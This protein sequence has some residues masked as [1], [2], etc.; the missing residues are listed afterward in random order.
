M[1][2]TPSL[3]T[4]MT[5]TLAGGG[6]PNQDHVV[7]TPHAVAVLDGATAERSSPSGRDGG[8]YAR[9]LGAALVVGLEDAWHALPE[10]VSGAVAGLRERHHLV[11]QECPTSTVA[12]ACWGSGVL[13]VYVLGD[14]P[15]VVYP[16]D[17][18]PVLVQDDRLALVGGAERARYQRHLAQGHG[19]D[20]AFAA[21]LAE[22]RAVQRGRRNRP[23]GYW[24][25][26][27]DPDAAAQGVTARFPLAGTAGVLLVTDGVADDVTQHGR[28]TWREV[29]ALVTS[30]DAG[31]YLRALHEVE[32]SD[33]DGRRW[34][35]AKPHD[36]KTIAYV[37][38]AG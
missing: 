13:D 11:P 27:S 15:A 3:I 9:T 29:R 24:I 7:V 20:E 5:A 10:I 22:L 28:R 19:Y 36:D 34:P 8:W 37:A 35:R 16:L 6:T 18:E 31:A 21:L 4:V 14:S 38:F 23:G 1:S 17:G 33:P 32:R 25:A 2:R 30:G 12:I 26:G